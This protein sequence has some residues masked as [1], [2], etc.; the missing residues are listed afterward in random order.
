MR[1]PPRTDTA[2]FAAK[3]AGLKTLS[4]VTKHTDICGQT[5]INWHRNRPA[6][7]AVVLE[8]ARMFEEKEQ[9]NEN[10]QKKV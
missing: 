5:L 4:I 2:A 3:A 9:K 6:L 7:F 8:G 10:K 1:K